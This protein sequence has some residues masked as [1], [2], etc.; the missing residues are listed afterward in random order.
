MLYTVLVNILLLNLL[1]SIIGDAYD[2]YQILM[3][4]SMLRGMAEMILKVE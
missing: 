2:R 3:K 4:S 1:I